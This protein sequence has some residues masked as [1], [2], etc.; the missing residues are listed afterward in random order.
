MVCV[1]ICVV[2]VSQKIIFCLF[3]ALI[4]FVPL[5]LW[6]FTSEVFEFNK[7][8]LVYILTVLIAAAWLIRSI[9]KKKFI[10]RPSILDIPLLI[11]LGSQ[12]IS[13]VLSID[14]YTSIFGYYS[15]FNGGLLSTICYLILYWAFVSNLDVKDTTRLIKIWFVSAALVSIYGV[16]EHFGIDKNIWVQDV[17]SRIFSTLGQPN[18]L[19][20]WVVALIPIAW[21]FALKSKIKSLNFWMYFALSILLFWV[22]IYTKSRSGLLGFGVAC[23]IFWGYEF[24]KNIKKISNIISPLFIIG[25]AFAAVCL[26]SGTELTPSISQLISHKKIVQVVD[27]SN[28]ALETGGTDSGIIRKIVWTGAI[29]VWLHY[30]IFGTGTETFAYSYYLYRPI[31]HNLT[32]E[33]NFIYNKAHNEFLNIAAN[34]GTL[35][36]ISYLVLIGFSIYLIIKN[37]KIQDPNCN[38]R[39]GILAGFISLSVS[40]FFGF[41]VVPT[42][43]EFFLFPAIAI[44]LAK[45]EEGKAKSEK[46]SISNSQKA[47]IVLILLALSYS[48]LVICRYWY[49]DTLYS[50]G[51]NYDQASRPDLAIPPLNQAIKLEPYQ[52]IYYG[53]AAN[54]Y[55]EIALAYSQEKE[56]TV[57]GEFSN[58]AVNNIEQAVSIAPSN[59]NLRR[60]LFGVYIML[61]TIDSKYLESARDSLVETIKMAPTDPKLEYNLGIAD[62]NLGNIDGAVTDFQKAIELKSNYT[63]ARIE[64]AAILVHLKKSDEAKSQLNYIL[65]NID[66][67]NSTAK[68]ALA[69]IK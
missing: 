16:A 2:K 50:R 62:A 57:A 45:S 19:A 61:S 65:K 17:Q 67:G 68:T 56:S 34:N 9:L 42:Q 41:S 31:A 39:F 36:L 6:P 28:T 7:M 21:A 40:N 13:T 69:N 22:L 51:Y 63:D 29:Q 24:F 25:F 8:I 58:L 38:L 52:S 33:W 55:T 46:V 12:L 37:G 20:A 66:P 4:F 26:I 49:A 1:T 35:G 54:S 47:F 53:E 23:I 14:F 18:W 27:T 59:I 11:F 44:T 5:V 3:A 10:F 32:S 43:L 64:Y 30:P 60:T 15:R 48:L